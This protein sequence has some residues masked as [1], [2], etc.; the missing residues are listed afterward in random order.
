MREPK[1]AL[2]ARF[3]QERSAVSPVEKQRIDEAVAA[4]VLQSGVYR[5][6]KTVFLYVSTA[7]EIDTSRILADAL[8]QGK[9]VCV[10]RCEAAR[11]MT[12]RR[13]RT[14][15]ELCG[16]GAFGILEPSPDAPIVSPDQIDLILAPALAC[17]RRGVRLGYGGGYYDRFLHR[18]NAFRA[19]LCAESRLLEALPAE[20]HDERVQYIFTERQVWQVH[21]T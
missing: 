17:D 1:S 6:A 9:T 5:A 8:R 13:I 12:A 2:R 16:A 18:S 15:E 19:A 20:P 14:Q 21:E 11:E 7:A 10:P 4:N 3:R